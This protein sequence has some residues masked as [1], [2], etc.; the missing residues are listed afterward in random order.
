MEFVKMLAPYS[1]KATRE[2]KVRHLFAIWDVDGD[3]IVSKEDMD[4]IIRQAAGSSLT[5]N[6]VAVL[7]KRVFQKAGASDR[8]L[9]LIQ[10]AGALESSQVGLCVDVPV[11]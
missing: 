7:V 11:E 3:G 9:D 6:E 10:F 4:L 2:D 8:G 1:P 5:D